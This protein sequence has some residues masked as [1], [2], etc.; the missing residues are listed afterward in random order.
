MRFTAFSRSSLI[1]CS[2][3]LTS[4]DDTL[5]PQAARTHV[6]LIPASSRLFWKITRK[7][8][9]WKAHR[10]GICNSFNDNHHLLQI[11]L[12][13]FDT[14][15]PKAGLGPVAPGADCRLGTDRGSS[16]APAG[17]A[18]ALRWSSSCCGDLWATVTE[19]HCSWFWFMFESFFHQKHPSNP[20]MDS[21]FFLP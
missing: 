4:E 12:C 14:G 11:G 7:T 6:Y 2:R 21:T 1:P 15:D 17:A 20:S 13:I 10:K 9:Q 8:Q 3:R 16:T 19:Q 5:W 18:G